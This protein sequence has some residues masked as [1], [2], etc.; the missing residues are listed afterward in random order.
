[1]REKYQEETNKK[2]ISQENIIYSAI[3]IKIR[4]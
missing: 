4:F 1:M 2:H 3:Y